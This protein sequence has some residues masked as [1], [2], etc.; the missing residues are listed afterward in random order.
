MEA[1]E[2]RDNHQIHVLIKKHIF[3]DRLRIEYTEYDQT[4]C[5][6]ER[7]FGGEA[8][9]LSA[10]N[11]PATPVRVPCGWLTE[12]LI[13]IFIAAG[14]SESSSQTV[15]TALV[16]ADRDGRSSHGCLLVPMYVERL[17]RGSVSR[18][19]VAT[20]V[21]DFGAI[22]VL[23]AHHMLGQVSGDQAMELAVEKAKHFGIGAVTV[24]RAFHFGTASRYA[25]KA[26]KQGC[27]GIAASNT[28]PLMPAP[29]GA[30]A[31]VG[32][33]PLAI[34]IPRGE[35]FPISLDMALSEVALGSIRLAASEGREIPVTWATDADGLPTRS[36]EA[37]IL[38]LLRPA[39]GAKGFGLA[40]VVDVL[41][42]VLSGGSFGA[43]VQGLYK[44]TSV[45]NDCA[46]IFLALNVEAF[47]APEEFYER[48]SELADAVV[49]SR[50]APGT[51][52]I[53]LPGARRELALAD[54]VDEVQIEAG[55]LRAL[56][57]TALDLGLELVV[58]V[59]AQPER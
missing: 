54:S 29:G 39:G 22:A 13:D 23:D 30:E 56:E 20:V 25:D 7:K 16:E 46:H 45:P 50:R 53:L 12:S 18:N 43:D 55:V 27:V 26:A 3:G 38:G 49:S 48:V 47:I 51:E 42:G 24:R 59:D 10:D 19:D 58:P 15:A 9:R 31:V 21:S 11:R 37:A 41:T 14:L 52:R 32:N 35:S 36:A 40:L 33:N 34:S 6:S 28:R 1:H 4:Q 44:D 5:I 57:N 2:L 17:R 8:R